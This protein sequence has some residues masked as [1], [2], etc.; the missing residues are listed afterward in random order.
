MNIEQ[1]IEKKTAIFSEEGLHS[2]E[3]IIANAAKDDADERKSERGNSDKY[4]L[5]YSH[6]NPLSE[7]MTL[8]KYWRLIFIVVFILSKIFLLLAIYFY[9]K[10]K[11]IQFENQRLKYLIETE[12][13]Q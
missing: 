5:N 10:Y 12:R 4:S 8:Q 9:I 2:L 11:D 1:R 3:K 13:L 7:K 6:R